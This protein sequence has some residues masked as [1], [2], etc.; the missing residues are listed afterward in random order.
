MILMKKFI[1]NLFIGPN[2]PELNKPNEAYKMQIKNALKV[3]NNKKDKTF[4]IERIVRLFL[5]Y[6]YNLSIQLC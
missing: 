6:I 4:G 5:I 2:I 3:W 1:N